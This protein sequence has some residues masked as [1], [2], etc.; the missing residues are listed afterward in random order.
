MWWRLDASSSQEKQDRND[1]ELQ[2]AIEYLNAK[3]S[4]RLETT[5]RKQKWMN[6]ASSEIQRNVL[7]DVLVLADK[8]SEVENELHEASGEMS[9]KAEAEGLR[10]SDTD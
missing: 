4:R 7:Q 5:E 1:R 9:R 8:I 10:V 6:G 3:R 2:E